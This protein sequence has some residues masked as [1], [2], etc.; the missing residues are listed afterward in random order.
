M[1]KKVPTHV[2]PVIVL[3][4]FAGTSLWF[5]GN[6]VVGELIAELGL[7]VTLVGYIT[8]SVQLGFITGTL[9]FAALSIADRFSPVRVFLICALMGALSNLL[10]I[11]AEGFQAVMA[12]RTLTGFFLAGIYPVGMKIASD[13][14][15]KGLG[16]ALGY[17]VGALV[18]GTAFPHLLRWLGES[19]AWKSVMIG[20][21]LLAVSGGVLLFSTVKDGP[22]HQK[23]G[24]FNPSMM[25]RLFRNKNF[26]YAAMGYFGHMWE[27]YTFW[28]FM[29]VML[30][31]SA[32]FAEQGVDNPLVSLFSFLIIGIGA[33]S[34][35]LLG[36]W[37]LKIGSKKV[38]QTSLL[39]SALSAALLPFQFGAP[40]WIF[41]L[42]LFIWGFF[43]I[44][45]SPQFSTL[46]AKS[47]YPSFKATG[48]TIVN[49]MGF[50]ITI[51]SIQLVNFF[52]AQSQNPLVFLL[53][54]PGPIAGLISVHFFNSEEISYSPK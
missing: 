5:A 45:D 11:F 16:K 24:A 47:C 44:P 30:A 23:S 34:C 51:G 12:A 6:A 40:A 54:L 13:W 48:L 33:F 53:M 9:V 4:Q 50:A 46:V 21:S 32:L 22:F 52:W 18:L 39:F 42:V 29:P 27:L 36:K 25:F 17:L 8:I 31:S 20:T 3:A 43:V 7:S 14:Y 41:L 10:V 19:L 49:S 15:S 37:S 1:Q 38:A 35:A 26:R 28:A 2:L